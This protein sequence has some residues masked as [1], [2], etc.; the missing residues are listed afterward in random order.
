MASVRRHY[1]VSSMLARPVGHRAGG[2]AGGVPL[3][4]RRRAD[5]RHRDGHRSHRAASQ[6]GCARKTSS[7]TRTTSPSR[8]RTSAPNARRSAS[9][10][11]LDT[12][13]SMAGEKWSAAVNA[14]DRFFRLTERRAGRVLPV[15][16]QRQRRPGRGL[17]QRSRSPRDVA[18]PHS[19]RTAARRCTTPWP[20]RCRWR[21]A[22]R[23]ARRR[24]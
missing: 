14:I 24:S 13:G 19:S 11:S 20:K 17:D 16:L 12:S 15:S 22:G 10:S 7:S 23:T 21:R 9:A 2:R 5:Q 4:E 18:Q 1:S 6:P 3:Q 8:S